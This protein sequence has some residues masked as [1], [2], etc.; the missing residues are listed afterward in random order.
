MAQKEGVD[1]VRRRIA[2]PLKKKPILRKAAPKALPQAEPMSAKAPVLFYSGNVLQDEM[3]KAIN[4][5]WDACWPVNTLKPLSLL[6]LLCYLLFIKKLEEK[7]LITESHTRTTNNTDTSPGELSWSGFKDMNPQNLHTV[8]TDENGVL[9][10]IR[11]YGLTNLKYSKFL[12]EPLMIIPTGRLLYS[13]I[14]IIKIMDGGPAGTQSAIFEYLLHK[15]EI[16]TQNGQVYAPD[17][18]IKLMIELMQPEAQDIIWDP[19]NGNG[20]LLVNCA[21]Y[22]T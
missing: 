7:R 22:I 21:K 3:L 8:F 12:K 17:K 5:K 19:S 11:N 9:N 4:E 18:A 13:M 16:E 6:D 14:A 1:R 2:S 10:L 20:S 15:A